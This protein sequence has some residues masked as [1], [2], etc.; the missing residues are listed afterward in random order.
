MLAYMNY[1]KTTPANRTVGEYQHWQNRIIVHLEGLFRKITELLHHYVTGL[2]TSTWRPDLHK[3]VQR[4]LHKSTIHGRVAIAKP[5]INESNAHMHK[6]RCQDHKTL[7]SDNRKHACAMVT[8]I[9]LHAVH[10]RKSLHLKNIPG[11]LYLRM[12]GSK[13]EIQGRFCKSLGGN[14]VVH[15]SVGPIITLQGSTKTGL[16]MRCIPWSRHYIRRMMEFS[17]MKMPPFRQL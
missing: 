1:G 15:Y 7:T 10:I 3:T 2:Q 12:L 5:L 6:W 11:S 14:I 9:V 16:V 8:W 13:S 17:K 4:A